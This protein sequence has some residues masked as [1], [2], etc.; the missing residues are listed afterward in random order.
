MHSWTHLNY[1]DPT[2]KPDVDVVNCS[3]HRNSKHMCFSPLFFLSQSSTPNCLQHL[4]NICEQ[5]IGAKF[6]FNLYKRL[7]IETLPKN[8]RKIGVQLDFCVIELTA[9]HFKFSLCL[10]V[11]SAR[12]HKGQHQIW[13]SFHKHRCIHFHLFS[14][15]IWICI[16]WMLNM[17]N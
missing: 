1:F 7:K 13:N 9:I 11:N 3:L 17:G 14:E 10:N 12:K 15:I 4:L 8:G 16:C 5:R 2:M 6:I